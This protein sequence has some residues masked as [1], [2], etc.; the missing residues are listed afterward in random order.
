MSLTQEIEHSLKDGIIYQ[1]Q[2]K[3]DLREVYAEIMS[4]QNWR[5]DIFYDSIDRIDANFDRLADHFDRSQ[6][7][8]EGEL[9]DV[10][11]DEYMTGHLATLVLGDRNISDRLDDRTYHDMEEAAQDFKRMFGGGGRGFGQQRSSS[12]NA[13]RV[14]DSRDRADRRYGGRGNS[15]SASNRSNNSYSERNRPA[16]SYSGNSGGG[17]SRRNETRVIAGV[18]SIRSP[19][20][21]REQREEQVERRPRYEEPVRTRQ[22]PAAV[23]EPRR[24]EPEDFVDF[25]KVKPLEN[26]LRQGEVWQL[27][28]TADESW[29][30][31]YTGVNTFYDINEELRYLVKGRDGK[32]REEFE[33]INDDNRY[34]QHEAAVSRGSQNTRRSYVPIGKA[35]IETEED[36]SYQAKENISLETILDNNLSSIRKKMQE[37]GE[38]SSMLIRGSLEEAVQTALI[39]LGKASDNVQ[40]GYGLYMVRDIVV[41]R[42]GNSV[43]EEQLMS[44]EDSVNL[45]DFQQRLEAL[46]STMDASL[47]NKVN[48]RISRLLDNSLR[49]QWHKP[50]KN[51]IDFVK[52]FPKIV[53]MLNKASDQGYVTELMTRTT[54]LIKLALQRVS[55]DQVSD[56]MDDISEDVSNRNLVVFIDYT[57]IV[58]LNATADELGIGRQLEGSRKGSAVSAN[59]NAGEL[60]TIFR[61]LFMA[62]PFMSSDSLRNVHPMRL[63]TKDSKV[64]TVYPFK[65]R[66]ADYILSEPV[67][68]I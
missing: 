21:E 67:D 36:I 39:D 61:G 48:R 11:V 32:I 66:Q 52:D 40:A 43:A 9:I 15:Y 19:T 34:L 18:D 35:T 37:Q 16:R 46:Q 44:L 33:M 47:F 65:A 1:A 5:S 10:I 45:T 29:T 22:E 12:P 41:L 42:N 3:G 26:F 49:Y 53:S 6:R 51:G 30:S 64:I 31:G 13:Y 38:S 59:S 68:L 20:P 24:E 27:A 28:A 63:I 62:L 60:E 7:M 50:S 56:V 17:Y 58:S 2:Q 14:N 25:T 4:Q 23:P 8:D 55:P 54:Y 57:H